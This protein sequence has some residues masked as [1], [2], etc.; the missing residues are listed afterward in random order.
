MQHPYNADGSFLPFSP[1]TI[2]YRLSPYECKESRSL[3]NHLALYTQKCCLLSLPFAFSLFA[4]SPDLSS[5]RIV[6]T[7][8]GWSKDAEELKAGFE[9]RY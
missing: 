8:A 3:A 7:V 2:W 6:V 9:M 1:T 5:P 4:P